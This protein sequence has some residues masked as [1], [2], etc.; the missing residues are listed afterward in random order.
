MS[1]VI[2]Q[3]D[4]HRRV[5]LTYLDGDSGGDGWERVV[6]E[7]GLTAM[8]RLLRE[9]HEAVRDFRPS[10]DATWGGHSEP[11]QPGELVCHG[12]FGPWNLVWRGVT[13]IGILDWDYAWP[14]PP[15]HDVAYALE[16]VTPFRTDR[17]SQ[18]W[19]HHPAPPDRLRRLELFAE[20]YGISAD[21][22]PHQVVEQQRAVWA[23]ARRLAAEG[24]EPQV[25]WQ[26][27]GSLDLAAQRIR[28]S[29]R[30]VQE[31]S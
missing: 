20:A 24:R 23:R 31:H 19:L 22:L 8:A 21:G 15:V 14:R 12:D 3:D 11:A 6:D 25:T 29:E 17:Y 9:Y 30:F 13:P 5:V 10:A 27:N 1:E 16:F 7:S 2:L 18:E 26:A 28:W 4:P